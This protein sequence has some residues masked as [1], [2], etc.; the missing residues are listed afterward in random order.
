[1]GT[2]VDL[3]FGTEANQS[4]LGV[5]AGTEVVLSTRLVQHMA[6][7]HNACRHKPLKAMFLAFASTSVT[8]L[9]II[10]A[11][12]HSHAAASSV[13]SPDLTQCDLSS[14]QRDTIQALMEARSK[15]C[16]FNMTLD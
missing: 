9:P 8:P 4:E 7:L 15:T 13:A 3:P 2:V 5:D 12:A 16:A 11:L 10:V 1:M 6:W 14:V